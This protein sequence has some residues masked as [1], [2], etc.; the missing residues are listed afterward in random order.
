MNYMDYVKAL[1]DFIMKLIAF[2][3]KTANGDSQDGE[4]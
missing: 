4:E 3:K 2:F 1:V